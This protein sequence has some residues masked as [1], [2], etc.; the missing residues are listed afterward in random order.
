MT[1]APERI[2][3]YNEAG[4]GYSFSA[5]GVQPHFGPVEYIRADLAQAAEVARL[6][7]KVEAADKLAQALSAC[8]SSLERA[9][10]AEGVCCCG[11]DMDRHPDPM[12]CGHSPVDMGAYYAHTALT[13]ASA[14]LTAYQ[15]AGK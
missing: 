11:A 8:V 15:E 12:S 2:T 3:A 4:R 7:A 9:D 14:T 13:E 6:R 10:T 5:F 1:D